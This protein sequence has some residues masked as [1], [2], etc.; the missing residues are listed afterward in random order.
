MLVY[1]IRAESLTQAMSL[2]RAPTI[3]MEGFEEYLGA[4]TGNLST[5][6]FYNIFSTST[7]ALAAQQAAIS[8]VQTGTLQSIITPNQFTEGQMQFYVTRSC[9]NTSNA[10]KYLSTQ[11]WQINN[12][13]S[14]TTEMVSS[15]FEAGLVPQLSSISSFVEQGGATVTA[16]PRNFLYSVYDTAAGGE[17]A[18]QQAA[19][20]TA[21]SDLQNQ[22]DKVVFTTGQIGFDYTCATGGPP[23]PSPSPATKT[24]GAWTSRPMWAARAALGVLALWWT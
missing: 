17:S 2:S 12:G 21:S 16:A 14:M 10:G 19:N 20:F 3:A 13:S 7:L 11:L 5:V 8:F 22:V 9:S 18:N 4:T 24:S 6:L 1:T 15:T 23:S